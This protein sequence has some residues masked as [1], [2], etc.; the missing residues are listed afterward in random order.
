VSARIPG[1]SAGIVST[2][3]LGPLRSSHSPGSSAD[4]YSKH[5]ADGNIPECRAEYY[6]EGNAAADVGC[7]ALFWRA[8]IWF[9][10]TS[11]LVV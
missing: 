5:E 6:A 2:F 3:V 1:T 4:G 10:S 7:N 9:G 11:F 8:L